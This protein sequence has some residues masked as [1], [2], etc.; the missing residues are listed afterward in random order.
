MNNDGS[1]SVSIYGETFADEYLK[2][3]GTK[4]GFVGMAN[5]GR[6]AENARITVIVVNRDD[7]R[8]DFDIIIV[9]H[10]SLSSPQGP[11]RTDV[12]SS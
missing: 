1:G 12:S 7:I 9:F 5:S 4:P 3:N 11:T 2:V 10:F 6:C 8:S